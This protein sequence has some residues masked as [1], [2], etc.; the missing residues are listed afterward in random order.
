MGII[1]GVRYLRQADT[2]S[3]L[4]GLFTIIITVTEIVWL[5]Q[6][7]VNVVNTVN[8]QINQQFTLYGL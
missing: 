4:V 1:W 7:T 5:I 8:Q 3:K 6:S 2:K